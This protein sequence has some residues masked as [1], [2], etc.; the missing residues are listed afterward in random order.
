[1]KRIRK[2]LKRSV[3]STWQKVQQDYQK[4]IYKRFKKNLCKTT[5]NRRIMDLIL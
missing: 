2:D 4:I 1:M 5:V 3:L